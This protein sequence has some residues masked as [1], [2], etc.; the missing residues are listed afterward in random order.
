MTRIVDS[1][2]RAALKAHIREALASR[3]MWF[4]KYHEADSKED[5]SHCLEMARNWRDR[6]K[7]R[8]RAYGIYEQ[9]CPIRERYTVERS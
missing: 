9:T 6:I 1:P 2:T 7:E 4:R 3:E 8:R 5:R